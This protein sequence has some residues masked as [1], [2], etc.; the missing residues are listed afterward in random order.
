VRMTSRIAARSACS[1]RLPRSGKQVVAQRG[2]KL[3]ACG[4]FSETK[5]ALRSLLRWVVVE[6]A[7]WSERAGMPYENWRVLVMHS[8]FHAT[9]ILWIKIAISPNGSIR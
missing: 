8:R 4:N 3:S 7:G 6:A 1:Q 2:W 9:L 5:R